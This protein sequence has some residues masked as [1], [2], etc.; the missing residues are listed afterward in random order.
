[1]IE[2]TNHARGAAAV[3]CAQ[4]FDGHFRRGVLSRSQ[5]VRGW[6]AALE[7]RQR[8]VLKDPLQTVGEFRAASGVDAIRK[9]DDFAVAG[10]LQETL[11]GRQGFD[12]LDGIGF[13]R[14]L[15]QRH[16]GVAGRHDG[17]IPRGLGQG[18]DGDAAA[19]AVGVGDQLVRGLDP[20]I[21]AGSRAPSIVEQDDQRRLAAGGN[22][23]LRIPDRAGGGQ[24]HQGRGQQPQRR[25]PP[26][27]ARRGFLLRR[28]IE[29]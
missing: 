5:R 10:R 12:P 29:Q 9:P 14:Q 15:A 4:H 17:D 13:W 11:D 28:D 7:N 21:P 22:P 3:S 8:A 27:R 26:R 20:H 18:D 1:M 6:R 23:A 24:D 19:V 2:R 25:Q 16:A